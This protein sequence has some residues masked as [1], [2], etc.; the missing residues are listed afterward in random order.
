MDLRPDDIKVRKRVR[1]DYGDLQALAE[2]IRKNGQITPIR[3]YF[4]KGEGYV[5]DVGERRR[6]ACKL[7]GIRVRAE[8]YKPK[9]EE[10]EYARFMREVDE[11]IQR[12]SFDPLEEGQALMQAKKLYEERFPQ[13]KAGGKQ[14][15]VADADKVP[16]FTKAAAQ[17]MNCSERK[18]YELMEVASMPKPV[19]AKVQAATTPVERNKEIQSA[20]K[21][22]R[23]NAKLDKLKAKAAA[24]KKPEAPE[25][26]IP[27]V[28]LHHGNNADY[29]TGTD[30]YDLILTD[31]PYD[32][33]RSA[34]AHMSRAG[35]NSKEYAW[36]KL[37][38]GWV[39]KAAPLLV[40]G[41]QM[42]IFC[43]VE[44][45]GEYE[46]V[47]K[48]AGLEYR[49]TLFW[50]KTNP[51]T[52]HRAIYPYAVECIVWLVKPGEAPYFFREKGL[53]AGGELTN[54]FPGPGVPGSA[55]D[56]LHETQKP[57]WLIESLLRIH[58]NPELFHHV[59]DPFAGSGTTGIAC[60]RQ[61]LA[62]TMVE[63]DA[64]HHKS[65]LARLR[66]EGC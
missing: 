37:D 20:L 51:A 60:R 35:V 2:N 65:A 12:K 24:R 23:Q 63:K 47:A 66:A 52:A 8:I 25:E 33:E 58:A 54:V 43:P 29:M 49:Q 10:P 1:T 45:V 56:R 13:T 44:A 39:L 14:E 6:R 34:I 28:V 7:L 16:R 17:Q 27:P 53:A 11:N 46:T 22:V 41:G 9:H 64:A 32:R 31:P 42:L 62:C 30:T 38:S 21:T 15:G 57:L 55:T 18:V 26:E 4:V 59:F 19:L 61:K 5:L 50:H 48:A 40:K 3:V 36:D